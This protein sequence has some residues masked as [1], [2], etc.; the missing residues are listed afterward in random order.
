[1]ISTLKKLAM[2]GSAFAMLTAA[3]SAF[4]QSPD[5]VRVRSIDFRGSGCPLG[6]VASNISPDRQAFT[7]LFDSYIAEVGQGVSAR[8]KRKNCAVNVD[9]DFPSGWTY[10]FFTVDYRGF[11]DLA[12]S[13]V[14]TQQTSYY[15]QGS[16]STARFASNISGPVS[17]DYQIRDN[18]AV[19]SQVWSPCGAQ[20]S[21]NMNTEVRIDNSRNL[22]GQGIMTLDSVDLQLKHIYGIRWRRC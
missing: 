14:G 3:S 11:V 6:S 4:A 2:V 1:M 20:R 16:P 13:Q 8:E 12:P 18:L 17:R 9:L 10:T 21:L 19:T 7:L 5:Y 22:R 15:F